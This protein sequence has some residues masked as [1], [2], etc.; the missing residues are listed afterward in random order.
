MPEVASAFSSPETF[1]PP[2]EM[3]AIAV[4]IVLQLGGLTI[5][6]RQEVIHLDGAVS[7]QGLIATVAGWWS[8]RDSAFCLVVELGALSIGDDLS[9]CLHHVMHL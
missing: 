9:R 5:H 3:E 2:R 7:W 4:G 6:E 1:N 8:P